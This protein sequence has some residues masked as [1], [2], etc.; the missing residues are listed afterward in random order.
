MQMQTWAAKEPTNLHGANVLPDV[1]EKAKSFDSPFRE[2]FSTIPAG[3]K[4]WHNRLTYWPTKPWDGKGLVTLAGDAAHPMTFHRGQGLNNAITDAA[5]LLAQLR[6]MKSHIP[7][8][9]AA[10]VKRY[11]VDLWPRGHEAVLASLENTEAVHDW[12]TMMQSPLFTGGLA[13]EVPNENGAAKENGVVVK[14]E[15]VLAPQVGS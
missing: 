13:K 9:L 4:V 15:M 12:N 14:E 5:E 6:A 11:E 1:Y 10:A 8:E 2:A 7:S 3:T